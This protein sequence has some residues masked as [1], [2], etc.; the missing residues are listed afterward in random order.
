GVAL[1]GTLVYRVSYWRDIGLSPAV[2]A[3]GTALDPLTVVFSVLAFGFLAQRMSLRIMGLIGGIGLALSMLPMVF[4]SNGVF[5]ILAHNV[6][7]GLAAGA[8]VTVN[9]LIWPNYYGVKFLGTIRGLILPVIVASNAFSA[10]LYGYVLENV[11]S[12]SEV[13]AISGGLFAAAGGLLFMARPPVLKPVLDAA[14]R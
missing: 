4:P 6:I 7:W 11:L 5:S 2:V 1:S 8:Y 3:L 10:P 12:P 13:W 14:S 9:N